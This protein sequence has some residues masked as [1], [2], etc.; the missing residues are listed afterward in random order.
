MLNRAFQQDDSSKLLHVLRFTLLIIKLYGL[1]QQANLSALILK[2]VIEQEL[3]S[4]P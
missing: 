1:A 4:F 2:L 3:L